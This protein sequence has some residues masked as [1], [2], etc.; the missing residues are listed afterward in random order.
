L[1]NVMNNNAGDDQQA[2]KVTQAGAAAGI[3]VL[4]TGAPVATAALRVESSVS[5]TDSTAS[6]IQ[7]V[8]TSTSTT[9]PT[10]ALTS[11][12]SG[13]AALL[14]TQNSAGRAIQVTHN[15]AGG[16]NASIDIAR[17]GSSASKIGG[18]KV[19]ATNAGVGGVYGIQV[20]TDLR[21]ELGTAAGTG[22]SFLEMWE[23]AS[24]AAAPAT[25][26]VRVFAKDN[27]AGKT[28]LVAR[29]PTGATVVIATEP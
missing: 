2:I 7:F 11:S 8:S 20:A 24:D 9:R 25:D 3:H 27:G 18:L 17:V 23:Q 19:S 13:N 12:G 15:D 16:A 6:L 1:L 10:M 29:F 21:V 26:S 5:I 14:L 28:Q 4:Q 22:K